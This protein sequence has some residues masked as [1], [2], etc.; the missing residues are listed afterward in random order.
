MGYAVADFSVVPL[1]GDCSALAVDSAA[2]SVPEANI[3]ACRR[4]R[5][6]PEG[7]FEEPY[8]PRRLAGVILAII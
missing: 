8:G 1:P 3:L 2:A 6:G 5:R 4:I 7:C